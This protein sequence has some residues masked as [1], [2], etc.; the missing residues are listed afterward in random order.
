MHPS[1]VFLDVPSRPNG[2]RRGSSGSLTLPSPIPIL[3]TDYSPPQ[4]MTP[5]ERDGYER[6]QASI[7]SLHHDRISHD[8]NPQQQVPSRFGRMKKEEGFIPGT[9]KLRPPMKK[10]LFGRPKKEKGTERMTFAALNENPLDMFPNNPMQVHPRSASTLQPSS[11]NMAPTS[12]RPVQRHSSMANPSLRNPPPPPLGLDPTVV[13]QRTNAFNQ[14]R[15]RNSSHATSQPP[16]PP[17]LP[18]KNDT[19][20][21]VLE[22]FPDACRDRVVQ[23]EQDGTSTRT[24]LCI[25]AD[26]SN[27]DEPQTSPVS[28]ATDHNASGSRSEIPTRPLPLPSHVETH[29]DHTVT[30]MEQLELDQQNEASFRKQTIREFFPFS[31][32]SRTN[33]LLRENSLATVMDIL[34]EESMD[35][36]VPTDTHGVNR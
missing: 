24:I 35:N 6:R 9:V 5:Q 13:D 31:K 32:S 36:A 33:E 29:L 20:N 26:E 34:A 16:S 30:T 10:G 14:P 19:I 8:V 15:R 18:L 28:L 2:R 21:A 1:S 17:T 4:I 7:D 27:N 22:I 3:S 25:L 11:T 12:T 23:L